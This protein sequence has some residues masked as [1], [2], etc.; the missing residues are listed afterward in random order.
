M[1]RK[2]CSVLILTTA[3]LIIGM[4]GVCAAHYSE[5]LSIDK[6]DTQ[7]LNEVQ[8]AITIDK[9]MQTRFVFRVKRY[10]Y[11]PPKQSH[12]FA[13][14]LKRALHKNPKIPP[15]VVGG[16]FQMLSKQNTNRGLGIPPAVAG[17]LFKSCLRKDLKYPP[18]AVGGITMEFRSCL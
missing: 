9:S 8:M 16:S 11:I 17:G 6:S 1:K 5:H 14:P 15:T 2:R 7:E 4:R 3:L 18:T 13:K 12:T 10:F